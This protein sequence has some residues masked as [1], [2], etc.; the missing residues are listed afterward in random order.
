MLAR[1]LKKINNPSKV[2]LLDLGCGS[3]RHIALLNDM[4]LESVIG[5]D[6]SLEALALC[7]E[8][9]RASFI[10][11]DNRSIPLCDS[12][13]DIAIAWGSLH[14]NHKKELPVML[15][16]LYRVLKPDGVLFGTLRSSRDTHLKRGM[17][18]GD[19]VWITDLDDIEGSVASFFSDKE[20]EK[21]FKGFTTFQYGIIERSL[22]GDMTKIISHWVFEAIKS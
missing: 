9:Y 3:G 13:I 12:C 19:D 17:H 15:A 10:A 20:L 21:A 16:E 11:C 5:A 22:M 7:R 1:R 4:G 2:T 6:I 18:L 8:H 14:Y